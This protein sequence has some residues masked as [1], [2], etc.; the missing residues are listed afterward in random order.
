VLVVISCVFM[1]FLKV[2]ETT[3]SVCL[4]ESTQSS[5]KESVVSAQGAAALA[6]GMMKKFLG[7]GTA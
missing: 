6:S 1:D 3:Q 5:S 7:N 2:E 4:S